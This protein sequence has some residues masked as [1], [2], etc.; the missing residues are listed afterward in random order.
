[1][2]SGVTV[3]SVFTEASGDANEIEIVGTGGRLSF[4]FYRFD[5][6]CITPAGSYGKRGTHLVETIRELPWVW[7]ILR[8]GGDFRESYRRQWLHFVDAVRNDRE[9]VPS[10]ADGREALCVVL[11]A[12]AS[13]NLGRP[14]AIADAPRQPQAVSRRGSASDERG[15]GGE[16]SPR[17]S[18]AFG[19]S[20]HS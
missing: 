19:D 18:R 5:S 13:A 17:R 2:S 3:S 11:A 6:L 9:P 12:G 16:R 4:S 7:P 14:L 1:M 10:A 20:R 15:A 8:R